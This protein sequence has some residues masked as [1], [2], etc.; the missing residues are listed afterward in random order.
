M[1][2]NINAGT[3]GTGLTVEQNLGQML[4]LA[5]DG[6]ELPESFRALLERR[7]VGGVTLFRSMNVQSPEQVRALTSQIQDAAAESGQ[8][9]L[10]IGADQEGGTLVALAGTTPFPGN[11]ALGATRS[12]DLARRMGRAVGRELAAMGININ[13]APVCDVIINAKNPVVGPRSFG[14]DPA[15]VARLAAA[16]VQGLQEEG[17]AATAKHFP[18]HGD[19]AVD[20]HHGMP[21]L[22]F[23]EERLR[24]VELRPFGEAVRAGVKLVMT[25]HIALPA[26]TGGV[27]I[28]ATLSP[29]ILKGIL[30]G[31]MGFDGVIVSDAMNM[32]G[33]LQGRD[34]VSSS[35][36]AA[37]AGVDLLMLTDSGEWMENV[38]AA[39]LEAVRQGRPSREEITASAR[40]VLALKEWIREQAS[41]GLDVVRCEEHMALAYAIGA[42][43]VTL[44]RDSAG[45]LPLFPAPDGRILAIVPQPE[46]LTPAD[47]SSFE[48]PGL[49]DA[50]RR[51]H[52]QVDSAIMPFKPS[53]GDVAALRE[54]ASGYDIVVIGTINANEHPGQ[55]EVVRAVL[56]T[57]TKVIAVAMRLPYDIEAYPEAP[58]YVCTYS[59]QQPS[60]DALA[61]A[62]WGQISFTGRLPV[63]VAGIQSL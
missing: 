14:E 62:M 38:Y 35:I 16:L 11:M 3:D 63:T 58:T 47:T 37:A 5:F 53:P 44:V 26:L 23:D 18:G 28:P 1:D 43:S 20:S 17:V 46:D 15:G 31:E 25:A 4:L 59:L 32:G 2:T 56:E 54:Q 24:R 61:D 22:P 50:L 60:L 57:G 13:Y 55:A 39:L 27:E 49:A 34:Y 45:L 41:P 29:E 10:L 51:H 36:E 21:V 19:T 6:M 42:E 33:V 8:P 7:H 52:A 9:P 40:R 48:T 30:R 12:P